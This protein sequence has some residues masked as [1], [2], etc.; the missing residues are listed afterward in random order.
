M[1]H[2]EWRHHRSQHGDSGGWED[3]ADVPERDDLGLVQY[4][5]EAFDERDRLVLA[6]T[7]TVLLERRDG[8][9]EDFE[10]GDVLHHAR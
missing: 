4:R 8:Y 7:R 5:L 9:R 6:G 3:L 1:N 2:Q 10:V